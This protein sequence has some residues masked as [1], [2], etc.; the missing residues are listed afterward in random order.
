[1]R[2]GLLGVV[3]EDGHN[4]LDDDGAFVTAL[5][6]EMDGAAGEPYA[7][8]EGLFLAVEA[9]EGGRQ[10]GV[11]VHDAVGEALHEEGRQ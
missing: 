3:G 11:D 10:R 1:M 7:V 6:H 5:A 8:F 2:Q 4:G 9:G